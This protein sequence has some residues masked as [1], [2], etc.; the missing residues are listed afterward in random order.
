MRVKGPLLE[1][2]F[3]PSGVASEATAN[4]RASAKHTAQALQGLKHKGFRALMLR[5]G[6]LRHLGF[7]ASQQTLKMVGYFF[8]GTRGDRM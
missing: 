7:K 2:S 3:G 4:F 5:V 6:C 1:G 8:T